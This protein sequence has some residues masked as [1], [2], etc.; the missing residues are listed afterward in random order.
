MLNLN[1]ESASIR[2]FILDVEV[3]HLVVDETLPGY[4]ILQ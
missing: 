4:A 2:W 3:N 1:T